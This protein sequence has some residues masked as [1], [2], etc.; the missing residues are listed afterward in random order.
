[1][2]ISKRADWALRFLANVD[3]SGDCWIW[4]G[5]RDDR[6]YGVLG[7]AGRYWKA[8]RLSYALHNGDLPADSFICHRCDNPPC[9]NPAHLYAGD[10]ATNARD[11]K[12]RERIVSHGGEK[13]GKARITWDI[14]HGIRENYATGRY[15]QVDLAAKYGVGQPHVSS[16][17]RRKVWK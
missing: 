13:C 17:I 11:A 4:V 3:G 8:H 6:G 15:R 10:A 2:T 1:M 5:R 7:V 12:E 14:V 9:V 16:I